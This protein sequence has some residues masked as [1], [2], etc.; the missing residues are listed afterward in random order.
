MSQQSSCY[1][2]GGSTEI[3]SL[4]DSGED[5]LFDSDSES[6]FPTQATKSSKHWVRRQ[7]ALSPSDRALCRVLALRHNINASVL[8]DHFGVVR[9]TVR[10]AVENKYSQPDNT[11]KDIEIMS[12]PNFT[13]VLNKFLEKQRH[14]EA[15]RN[16]GHRRADNQPT[17]PSQ[18]STTKKVPTLAERKTRCPIPPSTS[19]SSNQPSTS[20]ASVSATLPP[21]TAM[22][23]DMF[24]LTFVANVPLDSFW[25]EELK[26]ACFT[27]E[28]LRGM[29]GRSKETIEEIIMTIFPQM[30]KLDRLLFVTA[31]KDLALR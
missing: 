30:S 7:P 11:H 14:F 1:P 15:K 27:Q 10:K 24:L 17:R 9:S 23:G 5:D 6:S 29:A 13:E 8:S 20:M 21:A 28:K 22:P 2:K 3:L 25:Y 12:D 31:V 26:K 18:R 4:S 19:E 16:K